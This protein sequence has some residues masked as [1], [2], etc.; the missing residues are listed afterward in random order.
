MAPLPGSP[1]LDA[2]S[3]AQLPP[4]AATDQ[5]GP[6]FARAYG[7]APDIGAVEVQPAAPA[8]KVTA[9][10]PQDP[11]GN[12]AAAGPTGGQRSVVSQLVVTFGEAV[13]L[14]A[15]AFTLSLANNYGSGKNDGSADTDASSVLGAPSNPSGD[16]VTWVVPVVQDGTDTTY[17]YVLAA[18]GVSLQDGVYHLS[19]NASAVTASNG[20][21]PMASAY[22]S[23]LFHRLFGDADGNKTVNNA[24]YLKFKQSFNA[25]AGQSNYNADFDFD[26]NGVVNNSDYLQLKKRFGLAFGY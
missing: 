23:P 9:V 4:G 24:D 11:A 12:G 7:S 3:K 19:V 15:G 17:S 13:H 5:R 16:G 25:A 18:G 1:A 14:A 20:G 21:T 26:G 6:G 22:T 8:P 2:G 10:T